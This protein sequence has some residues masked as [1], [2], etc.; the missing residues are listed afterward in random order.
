[1]SGIPNSADFDVAII[2]GG[3]AGL[4]AAV[5]LARACRRVV[6]FDHGKPRNYAARAIHGFLGMDGIPPN[7]LRDRGRRE[8]V[9]YGVKIH[10]CKV[11]TAKAI[12]VHDHP[13]PRFEIFAETVSVR[14]RSVLLA[15][16]VADHLPEISGIHEL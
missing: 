8:A 12:T 7:D 3:P 4:S 13:F 5:V 1:M 14:T 9:S 6:L 2:G 16:G 11:N 15:T 10:D